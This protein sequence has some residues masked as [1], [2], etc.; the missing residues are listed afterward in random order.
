MSLD[1]YDNL[2][3]E[4]AN[5]LERNDLDSEIDSLIDLAEARHKREVRIREMIQRDALTVDSRQES[6]PTGFLEMKHLRLLTSPVTV[7]SEVAIN[8]MSRVRSES[9]GKPNYF[10]V[11]G[12]EIEFDKTPDSAYSG[13]IFFYKELDALDGTNTSNAILSRAPD[14]YLYGALLAA[15][16]FLMNDERIRTWEAL[17][18]SALTGINDLDRRRS[19]AL[20]SRVIGATP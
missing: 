20:T 8:E 17:Y 2:K 5:Y 19:G 11:I 10:S 12:S 3:A 6:L 4:I 7:L 9:T 13:E 1:T 15:E 16:P 14:L 18:S